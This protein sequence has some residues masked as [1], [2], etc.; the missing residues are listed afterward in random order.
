M[1]TITRE[2]NRLF[3]QATGQSKVEIY[4]ESETEFFFKVVEAQI[5][6]VPGPDGGQASRLILLQGGQAMPAE[7]LGD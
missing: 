7:R 6:F 1:L 5:V 4:P 2:E 3:A